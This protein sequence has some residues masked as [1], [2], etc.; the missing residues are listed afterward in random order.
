[1][2]K[3]HQDYRSSRK[4]RQNS[5]VLRQQQ[6]VKLWHKFL[7][8][9]WQRNRSSCYSFSGY[10]N[11]FIPALHHSEQKRT[12]K[13]SSRAAATDELC[14]KACRLLLAWLWPCSLGE[15]FIVFTRFMLG[16]SLN[17]SLHVG[18]C[19]SIFSSTWFSPQVNNWPFR[20]NEREKPFWLPSC[21]L[22]QSNQKG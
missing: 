4:P 5:L 3:F 22:L 18:L 19:V 8:T 9:F 11:V 2:L 14:C 20:E 17:K 12:S 6:S 1:M 21:R 16:L 10:C 13:K 15:C 7:N